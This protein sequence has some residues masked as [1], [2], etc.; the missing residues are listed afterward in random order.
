M[1]EKVVIIGGGV[2][3]LT[4]AHELID[5]GF[6][7]HVYERRPTFG[8]KAASGRIPFD[9]GDPLEG[10][11][12]EHGFRF[13]P[14]WYRHLPDTLRRIPYR[15]KQKEYRGQTVYNNLVTINQNL[16]A[17]MNRDNIPLA[18]A[19]PRDLD[20]LSAF[21]RMLKGF[22]DLG[23]TGAEAGTFAAKMA[24]IASMT[25]Q[26]RLDRLDG[27]TWWDFL[28]ANRYKSDAYAA[29]ISATTRTMVAAKATEVSA[30]TIGKLALRTFMDTLSTVDRVLN[31]TTQEKWIQ[32]WI[33][34]LDKRGVHFH[35]GQELQ[36][37]IP[38]A[39]IGRQPAA[40][41]EIAAVVFEPVAVGA[42]RRLRHALARMRATARSKRLLALA[43]PN[44]EAY[45]APR[46]REPDEADSLCRIV[47][48]LDVTADRRSELK[49]E[50]TNLLAK[51]AVDDPS[52]ADETARAVDK[53]ARA[54]ESQIATVTRGQKSRD[55]VDDADYFIF[56]LPL[57]QM[58]YQINRSPAIR[59]LDPSLRKLIKLSGSLDWMAG[60]QFYLRD[61]VAAGEG[62]IVGLD[63]AWGLTAIEHTQHW[64]DTTLPRGVQSVLSVDIAAWD[65]L[66][67]FVRKEAFNCTTLEIAEE[68]WHQLETMLNRR[69]R[70]KVLSR[71]M[72][73]RGK[74]EKGVSFHL[75]DSVVDTVDRG[76]QG[77]YERARSLRFSAEDL[78]DD[79]AHSYMWGPHPRFNV[80]PI[81]INRVGT[82]AL[83]PDADTGIRNMFLAADYVRTETDLA[84]MEGANEA[85][86]RAVNALLE[87][88]GS[89][90]DR[91]ELWDFSMATAAASK[92]LTASGSAAAMGALSAA[93]SVAAG[94]RDRVMIA[95]GRGVIAGRQLIAERRNND[96][97]KDKR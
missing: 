13:F 11:P 39:N 77:F 25:E 20:E 2:G 83:R 49:E 69:H 46:P 54:I 43:K 95:M 29:L 23:L 3:G 34:H 32:P 91:C 30:Y 62:H 10:L 60:I 89:T 26:D 56:A 6:E 47:D 24:Q 61:P 22:K 81:L 31:G 94:L 40:K 80:E 7:V 86:R 96:D 14:G 59:A 17:W 85:A 57:E 64:T 8:G 63:S 71:E 52:K 90:A 79:F 1:R 78:T 36:A 75:D 93:R 97:Y 42:A 16:L 35:P 76:K 68:V 33:D 41:D 21:S 4:A 84:C 72:L 12:T 65:R 45:P 44:P 88:A 74:L 38:R 92:V 70:P 5:R 28:E 66:G 9:S 15:G 19:V 53:A 55:V 67:H 58:A 73:V 37:I 50:L 87:A 18:L 82:R 51:V 27:I 48:L